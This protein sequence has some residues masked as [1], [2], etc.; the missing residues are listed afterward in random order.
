MEETFRR[1]FRDVRL[2]KNNQ[3]LEDGTVSDVKSYLYH[4]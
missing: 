4:P 2:Q 3:N 1:T